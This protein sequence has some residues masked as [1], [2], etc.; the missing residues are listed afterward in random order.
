MTAKD[1]RTPPTIRALPT[2]YA[3]YM[4]RS[5]TEARWAYF[6]DALAV[7][8]EYE[9]EGFEFGG[10]GYLPDFWLP[11]QQ[12]WLEIKGVCPTPDEREKCQWLAD[13]TGY[14]VLV[15]WGEP[16][17]P[18]V[19]M[20]LPG[21]HSDQALIFTAEGDDYSHWWCVC[22]YCGRL[23]VAFQGRSARLPCRCVAIRHADEDR[24]CTFGR[25]LL[26][27]AYALARTA[28]TGPTFLGQPTPRYVPAAS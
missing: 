24:S 17:P 14:P 18:D 22:P 28:F 16:T 21:S 11:E 2:P 23:D 27:D 1:E 4:F 6:F 13:G 19:L 12:K 25:P 20:G 10:Q 3:G 5:R 8:W 15:A 7:P 26:V 9:R